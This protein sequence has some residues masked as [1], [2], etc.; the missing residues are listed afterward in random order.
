M[1]T[2]TIPVGDV[3]LISVEPLAA[4]DVDADEQQ[5]ARPELRR[6][7]L[8]NLALGRPSAPSQRR[9]GLLFVGINIIGRI[10]ND[11]D[12]HDLTNQNHHN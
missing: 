6:E 7:R 4:D 9:R 1:S 2:A 10:V 11:Q 5:S 12:Q 3:T 8:A